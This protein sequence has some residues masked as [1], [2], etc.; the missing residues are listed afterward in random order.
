MGFV[1]AN[2]ITRNTGILIK[3]LSE[4]NGGESVI[5]WL[6]DMGKQV[7]DYICRSVCKEQN[8]PT[9]IYL[10]HG[11][12]DKAKRQF[13]FRLRETFYFNRNAEYLWQ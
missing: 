2:I 6:K 3:K 10:R 12:N 8:P 9:R 7:P 4:K 1:Q 13:K 5:I 11:E